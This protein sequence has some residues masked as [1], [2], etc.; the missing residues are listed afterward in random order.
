MGYS[1]VWV[2]NL[3]FFHLFILGNI[4]K[5]NVFYDIPEGKSA[6]LGFKKRI[7]KRRKTKIFR[8]GVVHGFGPKLAIFPS[9][10]V[11]Q[12]RSGKGVLRYSRRK[13]RL[14]RL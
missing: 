4:G 12:C 14:S 1:M 3:P 6:F 2:Q 7:S 9:F 13:K 5:E 11:G 8:K 10:Y